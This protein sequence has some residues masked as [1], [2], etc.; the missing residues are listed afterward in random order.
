[1]CKS[2]ARGRGKGSR[3]PEVQE[4]LHSAQSQDSEITTGTKTKSQ[5]LNLLSH[6]GTPPLPVFIQIPSL[7]FFG[8]EL[9]RF[10]IYLELTPYQTH[11]LQISS[12]F[13]FSL[14]LEFCICILG[15]CT[16][17]S[18]TALFVIAKT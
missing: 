5:M 8:V 12:P 9:Y 18:I 1:M 13:S 11:H 14:I 16:R 7:L 6:P 10:F 4:A 15:E 3:L 2:R 17:I